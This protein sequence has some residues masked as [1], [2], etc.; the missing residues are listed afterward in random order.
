MLGF[1]LG[2]KSSVQYITKSRWRL[3]SVGPLAGC[4]NVMNG[5]MHL[6]SIK[7]TKAPGAAHAE[8]V[9]TIP[10]DKLQALS[11]DALEK[12]RKAF[13]GPHAYG[14]VAITNIPSYGELKRKAFRAG[15]DLALLDADGRKTA[16]AVNN[17]YPGWSGT[18]GSETHPLQSSFLFNV[19]EELP[20]G[21]PD[22][23][24]GKNIFPSEEYKKTW[25]SFSTLMYSTALQVLRGCDRLMEREV[26]HWQGR[27]LECLGDQGPALAG[28]FICYDSGFTREDRLL[29]QAEEA[30]AAAENSSSQVASAPAG[31]QVG[32]ADDGLASMRTHSTPV[33]SAGH[34]GD[35]LASMR[36]HSTPV[37]T[38]GHAGDGL[39][40][41]RTHSTPVKSAGHAGD[42]LASMRTHSTP[43]KTAGHAGDGLASMRTHSTPVKS[44]GHAG[45]GLASMR[46]HSTPVKT[47][48]HAGDGLASMRT[49]STPVKSAG[50]AGDGL[51]SMRTHSTPVKTAGHAGDG[52][53]SMR[54]HST[55]VKSAGHAGDG[56]A[57]MRTHSTP[58]KT[59]GHAGDG[60][61]SMRTHSTPVKSAGHAG[62]GLASMR[63]HSTPV[64]TSGHAGDGLASTR[65]HSMPVKSAGLGGEFQA[66]SRAQAAFSTIAEPSASTDYDSLDGFDP[67][68]ESAILT[69]NSEEAA[70]ETDYWLPWHI[71]SNFVTILHQE[72]YADFTTGEF[73]PPPVNTGLKMMNEV[74]QTTLLD[75]DGH[76]TML[77]QF[78][79]FG[80]IYT[81]GQIQACRHAVMNPVLPGLT[82]FNFC[83]FWYVPWQTVCQ[84]PEGMAD[85]AVNKGWNAMMD[86]QYLDITM[87]QSFSA[88]R[89]F[90]VSPEA[91]LQFAD[92][93]RFKELSE[94]LPM[95]RQHKP[96]AAGGK[97]NIQVDVLTD[98]RCPFS[99][100]SQKN[101][102]TAIRNQ[103]LQDQVAVRYHPIFLNPNIPKEGLNLDDYLWWEFGHSK[104]Y[105][106]SADYPLRKHGREAGIDMNPERRVVNTFDAFCL[107]EAAQEKGVQHELVQLLSHWYFEA[108]KD[109]SDAEVLKAAAEAVGL[110]GEAALARAKELRPLVQSRYEEMS[111]MLGEVPHFLLREQASGKGLEVGG[112]RTVESWEQVLQDVLERG[113]FM[114][115]TID[116]PH[117]QEVRLEVANPFGAVSHAL[118]A[119]HGWVPESWPYEDA[120]FLR[121]DERPDVVFHE[122]PKLVQHLD[123]NSLHHLTKVYDAIFKALPD[124]FAVL[125]LCSSWVSHYP[126]DVRRASQVAVHGL[127]MAELHANP[128][129]TERHVQDL[130]SEAALPWA[131]G[132]FDLVTL[133]LSVQYLT[134]PRA[135]FA[136]MQRVLKPGGM[137]VVAFSHRCFIEKAVKV[138]AEDTSNGEGQ[139]HLICQ[140]FQHGPKNGWEKVATADVSPTHGDPLWLV[141]AVKPK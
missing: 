43:V 137:A 65:T 78:G 73:V 30:L 44:A 50:H 28:R 86:E 41:M 21:K 53:A 46:T 136:E 8:P 115:M 134:N 112:L 121:M 47:A 77:L 54:T 63:T 90:M 138:W 37:K 95:V 135:V 64:K 105:A 33:K 17:T 110:Q 7:A 56:L 27:S 70:N 26:K 119:Q 120:D 18:P 55:P 93:Q 96:G 79:A 131:A 140:Y 66:S 83:N 67:F 130:N 3:R 24:F 45:D 25:V 88:F 62:D 132:S 108:A 80:Q 89:Q 15:I 87:R 71:D 4:L 141:T 60:L 22:P 72:M 107:I 139:A 85:S 81:G 100:I 5:S 38:A 49:H 36:T 58:V 39:A 99:F 48:G 10:Y 31:R 1:P 42:G 68:G 125:D 23:F 59:A 91:R 61:A 122:Q 76:D 123:E 101:L 11:P 74:G 52:L 92:S 129:A 117:G 32:H 40:S 127:N 14:A 69:E 106:R 124:D 94:V 75:C 20:G 113:N 12:L 102:E 13:V 57:S 29:E 103:S 126:E 104:E 84:A 133:A 109:I 118:P 6:V 35:G 16:A 114:G 111:A 98:V 34:A 19:K 116:G 97:L 9:V 2:L 128:Q 51:A 82:R